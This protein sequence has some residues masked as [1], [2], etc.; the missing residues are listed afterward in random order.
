VVVHVVDDGGVEHV[1][2]VGV[3]GDGGGVEVGEEG[4]AGV[5]LE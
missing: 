5:G 2:E 1:E 3:V 4:G